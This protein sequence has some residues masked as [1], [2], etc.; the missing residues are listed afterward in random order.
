MIR[1]RNGKLLRTIVLSTIAGHSGTGMFPYIFSPQYRHLIKTAKDTGTPIFT[2]S[3]TFGKHIG[4]VINWKPWTIWQYIRRIENQGM[5]NAYGLTNPGTAVCAKEISQSRLFGFNVIPN[6]YPQFKLKGLVRTAQAIDEN[7][8]AIDIYN[9]HLDGALEII[10]ENFS[11]PNSSDDIRKNVP[12]VISCLEAIQSNFPNL[13]VI[14]KM[15]YVQPNELFQEISQ[16]KLADCLHNFNTIDY[17][18]VFGKPSPLI[19]GAGG[20][21]GNPI[22]ELCFKRNNE[23]AKLVNLPI[24]MGGG[25]SAKLSELQRYFDIG[26]KCLSICTAAAYQP[27]E[28]AMLLN[29]QFMIQ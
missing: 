20:A 17:M 29:E 24:I 19:N 3:A 16:R 13:C 22:R 15:S 5:V 9:Q 23:I 12:Q 27:R 25:I 28:T 18:L 21:S 11:C 2:K 26:A 6:Y 10:E 14:A 8:R 4:N 1:L 7:L